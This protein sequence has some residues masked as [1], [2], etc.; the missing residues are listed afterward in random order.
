MLRF[1][2]SC[3][4]EILDSLK[5][6]ATPNKHILKILSWIIFIQVAFACGQ[7]SLLH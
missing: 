1:V 3:I 6:P 4:W 5:R 7:K 2:I